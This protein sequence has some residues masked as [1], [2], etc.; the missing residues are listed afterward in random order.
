MAMSILLMDELHEKLD[1][2]ARDQ[3]AAYQSARPFP[4]AS[5][6]DVF[7]ATVLDQVLDEWPTTDSI[8]WTSYHS[9]NEVKRVS[10]DV[11]QLGPQTRFV[12]SELNSQVFLDFL[13]QLTGI[14][15]LVADPTFMAGGLS[16]V[17]E[18]GFLNPHSDF[19]IQKRT[20]LDRR[21]NVLLYL[22]HDWNDENGG[23]FELWNS[24]TGRCDVSI[25]PVFNRMVIFNTT[26]RAIHGHSQPVTNPPGGSRKCISTYYF[27]RGRPFRELLF[28][29]QGVI[30][31]GVDRPSVSARADGIARAVL[32]PVCYDGIRGLLRH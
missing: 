16:D 14:N 15:G 2:I 7:P 31:E 11:R 23:Q 25:P 5:L 17:G 13:G 19:L 29:N 30:F 9:K 27:S 22:N 21:V 26:G 12:L 28:G 32:P 1:R 8:D 20:K 18:G 10:T 3:S 24:K 4:H 6:D